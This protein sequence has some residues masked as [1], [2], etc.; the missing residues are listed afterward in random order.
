VRLNSHAFDV[1]G[2]MRC[3][4][5][6]LI[7]ACPGTRIVTATHRCGVELQLVLGSRASVLHVRVASTWLTLAIAANR[8]IRSG[9]KRGGADR[10]SANSSA[11]AAA[12]AAVE[13]DNDAM[14]VETKAA[15]GKLI[16]HQLHETYY[17]GSMCY[18]ARLWY[19]VGAYFVSKHVAAQTWVL[20]SSTLRTLARPLRLCCCSS[21]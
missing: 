10:I 16:F 20:S 12:A 15:E 5:R 18:C 4:A 17:A 14:D 7:I 6:E 2:V 21:M 9:T 8:N 11:S 3:S 19:T 1:V 13:N